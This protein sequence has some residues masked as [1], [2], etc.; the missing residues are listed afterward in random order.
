MKLS[1]LTLAVALSIGLGG[2]VITPSANA[3]GMPVIDIANLEQ[4]VTQY[5]NM[6]E[7]LRQL[8]AQLE[9]AKQ[10]YEA[11]T[12][13]RSMGGISRENY[14]QDIPKSWQE[15][16]N[17]MEGGGKVGQLANQIKDA[18][19]LLESGDFEGVAQSVQETLARSMDQAATGQALNALVYDG[20]GERFERIQAL[21]DQINSADDLKAITDL[22][23][24][25]SVENAMLQNEAIKLQAMNALL[26]QQREVQENAAGQRRIKSRRAAT[27]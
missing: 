19:S 8:E 3:T 20:S 26:A 17:A 13:G 22:S 18:A 5:M 4:Q 21:M 7:Q 9:Q 11:I 12:G 27:Y 2:S 1:S 6:V 15:T 14:T 23:V 10:Q 16:L 25:V 24:R